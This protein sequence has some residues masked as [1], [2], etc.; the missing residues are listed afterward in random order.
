[1]LTIPSAAVSERGQLQ[2]VLVA[3][4]GAAHNRLITA[5]QK[6]KDQVE[7]LSGLTAGDKVIVPVPRG[8]T[9]GAA[10]EV[11]P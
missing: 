1:M 3:E 5:G 6:I 8:L 7:V 2:S 10:V 4:N 11:R 9:D